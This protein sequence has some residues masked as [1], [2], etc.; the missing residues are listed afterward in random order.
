MTHFIEHTLP[1][2]STSPPR[3][4][5]PLN[6]F[7][8]S[9]LHYLE[10]PTITE[11]PSTAL[12]IQSQTSSGTLCIANLLLKTSW[13]YPCDSLKHEIYIAVINNLH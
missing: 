12:I 2:R 3:E 4:F 6:Q 11:I 9:T 1:L 10:Q 13:N 7:T 5:I 8:Q